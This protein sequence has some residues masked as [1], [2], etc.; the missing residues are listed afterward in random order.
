[1]KI[2]ESEKK[3]VKK[4]EKIIGGK[5]LILKS[6]QFLLLLALELNL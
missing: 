3:I 4:P 2:P 6:G 5:L 1:M